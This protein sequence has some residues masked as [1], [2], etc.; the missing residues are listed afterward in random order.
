MS[1]QPPIRPVKRH[2]LTKVRPLEAAEFLKKVLRI[3]RHELVV[4]GLRLWI[5]PASNVG[6]R[7]LAEGIYERVLTEAFPHLLEPGGVFYDIGANEGWFSLIAARLVGPAGRVIAVEPQERLWPVILQNA[8]LNRMANIYLQ[9]FAIAVD[10]SESE[11]HL[12]PSVNTGAS[13]LGGTKRR[14]EQSQ[15][16]SLVP[17]ARLIEGSGVTRIDLM[18]IDVEGFELEVLRS[19]GDHLGR[20]IRHLVVE[21]HESQLAAR[22]ESSAQVF[23]LLRERGYVGRQVGGVDYWELGSP[24]NL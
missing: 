15:R 8:S 16:V 1:I 17:L 6:S 20:T 4:D 10:E 19:A 2:W 24:I 13:S 23:A 5:D 12:Y 18:K 11:I 9:P 7:L 22:G 3:Q 21:T 14:F